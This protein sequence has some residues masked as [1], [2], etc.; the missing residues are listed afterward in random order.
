MFRIMLV[1]G[2][3]S[4]V[5]IIA[6]MLAG[7]AMNGGAGSVVQGFLTMLVVLSLI[8][9]G[10]KR[11]RDKD[12]GGVIKFLPAFGLGVGIAAVAGVFYVLS[13]EASLQMTDFA[14]MESYKQ[15]EIAGYDS[16]G[17]TGDEL[18]EK[19]AALEDMMENYKNPIVRLPMTFIEIFPVGCVVALVSAALLRNPKVFPAKA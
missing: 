7:M 3:I 16:K 4:G 19:V 10:V 1:Y 14:W 5:V 17:L 15:G 8:F 11:Y 9:V 13:W 18:A 2:A 6:V 12:L